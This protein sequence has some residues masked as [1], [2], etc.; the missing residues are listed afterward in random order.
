MHLRPGAWA[1]VLHVRMPIAIVQTNVSWPC[2]S[3]D[4]SATLRRRFVTR[5][6]DESSSNMA[7]FTSV[8]S[9]RYPWQGVSLRRGCFVL[10]DPP[11]PC[12]LPILLPLKAESYGEL[13]QAHEVMS[14]SSHSCLPCVCRMLH[15]T[16]PST[17]V[18]LQ[19]GERSAYDTGLR[20]PYVP[21]ILSLAMGR[22][23][24]NC[25]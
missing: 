14:G 20:E 19:I 9:A 23:A 17:A 3:G 5:S 18:G 6:S 21:Y 11:K 25:C 1:I 22:A 24:Y 12:V 2:L 13:V 8:S 4:T 7:S 10:P 16:S 15:D